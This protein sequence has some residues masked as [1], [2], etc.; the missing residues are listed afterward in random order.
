MFIQ[1]HLT[2]L[3]IA[4]MG[5]AATTIIFVVIAGISSMP[6]MGKLR[7]LTIAMIFLAASFI[8]AFGTVPASQQ[9]TAQS[10]VSGT[11]QDPLS[12]G[13]M[14][15]K[16]VSAPGKPLVYNKSPR[17]Y[18]VFTFDDGPGQ[19]T[20]S[21]ISELYRLNIRGVFFTI[22]RKVAQVPQVVRDLAA[23][24]HI[25]AN[26]TW[27]HKSFTGKGTGAE[28]LTDEQVRNELVQSNESLVAAG[29]PSPHYCR[30]P[31]GAVSPASA[32]VA[33]N[34]GLRLIPD[35]TDDGVFID[36][37]DWAGLTP[38]RITNRVTGQ[39]V[40]MLA[41]QDHPTLVVTFHDGIRTAPDMIKALPLIV[42]WMNANN[43]SATT[44][45]PGAAG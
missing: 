18:I 30:A 42:A 15:V 43:V 19:Y 1:P 4:W 28:P 7:T 39:M 33:A 22:G 35:S 12:V 9:A 6:K 10:S 37:G 8:T 31:Y 34:L 41:V 26:H 29:L 5:V 14:N 25:V 27:D 20:P 2:A 3:S 36:S 40:A 24:G 23:R 16:Q 17:G 38:E 45:M 13:A 21:V 44:T 32:A 11:M